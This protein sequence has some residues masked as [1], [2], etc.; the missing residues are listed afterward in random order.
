MT[1]AALVAVALLGA[2][3]APMQD[4]VIDAADMAELHPEA[5]L[6]V[7][8]VREGDAVVSTEL[9]LA[10]KTTA[11]FPD[12]ILATTDHGVAAYA[13]LDADGVCEP[14]SDLGWTFVYTPARGVDFT[15]SPQVDELRKD[16]EACGW[17]GD[18]TIDT[19]LGDDTDDTDVVDTDAD[20]DPDTDGDSDAG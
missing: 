17:F 18:I 4:F 9:A 2:C 13:D 14:G 16:V 1:R 8:L 15:W 11:S 3:K 6:Y 10:E 5:T 20:S 19:D 7:D 12:T